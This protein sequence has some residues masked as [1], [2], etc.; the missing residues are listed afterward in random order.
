MTIL[1]KQKWFPSSISSFA[2]LL[3]WLWI[4]KQSQAPVAHT[5]NP[6]YLE[7]WDCED[8][9]YRQAEVNSLWDHLLQNNYSK[10]D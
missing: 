6:S 7:G 10:M 3:F 2:I 9:G 8:H 1:D 4:L 5:Y